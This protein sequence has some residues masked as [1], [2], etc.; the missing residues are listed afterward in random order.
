MFNHTDNG[1]S[2]SDIAAVTHGGYGY[3]NNGILPVLANGGFGGLGGND[4]FWLIALFALFALGGWGGFGGFGGWGGMGG[5]GFGLGMD[6]LMMWPW[7]M[8]QNTDN[9]VQNGFNTQALGTQLSGIQSSV[10]SGFGDTALGIAGINQ[11]ICNTGSGITAAITNGFANAEVADNAR[12]IANMQQAFN[13]Q[14]ATTAAINGV[15]SD[16]ASCCCENR[17][18]LANLNSTILSENCA[19]RAAISDGIRDL[20]VASNAN[21]QRILDTLCQDKIDAKNEK[22]AE[23]QSQINMQNLAASQAAQT[24]ALVADNTAQTQYIVNRVAPYP[25]PAYQV[26]NPYGYPYYNYGFGN[27]GCGCGYNGFVA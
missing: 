7:M 21:T 3:G 15:A 27:G 25:I 8:T 22:I 14:T 5:L 2:L 9:I 12:Q 1:Y 19:D 6:N 26:G 13:S 24:A 11:N 23:L 4:G 10:T 18:G 20:L 16:L 17:L